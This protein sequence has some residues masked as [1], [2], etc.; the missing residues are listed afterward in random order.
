MLENAHGKQQSSI[1][2]GVVGGVVVALRTWVCTAAS[3]LNGLSSK[4][5]M[6]LPALSPAKKTDQGERDQGLFS[7]FFSRSLFIM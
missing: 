2:H 7:P 5:P 4:A 1:T 6:G 3:N